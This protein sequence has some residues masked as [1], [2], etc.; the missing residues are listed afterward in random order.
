MR[1]L[2][3]L[4][5]VF[6]LFL[7]IPVLA[8]QADAAPAKGLFIT[9][10]GETDCDKG[11]KAGLKEAGVEFTAVSFDAGQDKAKL[12]AFLDKLNES[13][14]DFIYTFGTTVSLATAK[15]VKNTP[16]F[17]GIVSSPVASGL[18]QSWESSG[19]NVTGVSHMVP[20]KDQVEFITRLKAYKKIGL[21]YN[22]QEKNSLI[23]KQEL[24][25][26]LSAKGISLLP[27]EA[28]EPGQVDAAVDKLI[29][30][31]AG[32]VY[33]PSDSFI[34]SR[35]SAIVGKL[36]Q[37]KV[38]TYGSVEKFIKA[39]GALVGI[40]S[41]YEMVGRSLA[42]SVQKVLAGAKP[43]AVPS[44][45]LPTDMQTVMVNGK[46]AQQI[47]AELPYEILQSATILE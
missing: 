9:W 10:R 33:L 15:K 22:P 26:L 4:S 23:A 18:I 47:G 11:L 6:S 3:L 16:V 1:N 32:L 42:D 45:T 36:N 19:N 31:G 35:A 44:S 38:P 43:S 34:L 20:Y 28:A 25:K 30:G 12:E 8:S 40:V 27:A 13:E 2:K 41:S 14:Y 7:L 17:F 29:S 5:L 21:I 37:A 39:G 46:T 24:E